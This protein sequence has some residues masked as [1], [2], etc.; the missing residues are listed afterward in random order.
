[1]KWLRENRKFV[2]KTKKKEKVVENRENEKG[3]EI[4]M[5]KKNRKAE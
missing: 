4:D 2:I 1:M 3:K 5:S